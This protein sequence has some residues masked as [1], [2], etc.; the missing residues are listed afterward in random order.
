MG[1]QAVQNRGGFILITDPYYP[2]TWRKVMNSIRFTFKATKPQHL[3]P[4]KWWMSQ[5]ESHCIQKTVL[6]IKKAP[7]PTR[8]ATCSNTP[9]QGTNFKACACGFK[10]EPAARAADFTNENGAPRPT[11]KGP[12]FAKPSAKSQHS[13]H[14]SLRSSSIATKTIAP[15]EF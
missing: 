9:F 13:W 14:N 7:L 8:I 12:A 10:D 3:D 6:A 15:L 4:D 5:A 1:W 2:Q 11:I